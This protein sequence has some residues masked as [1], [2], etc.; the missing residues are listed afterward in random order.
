[1][2]WLSDST[3]CFKTFRHFISLDPS[4]EIHVAITFV[5]YDRHNSSLISEVRIKLADDTDIPIYFQDKISL[6]NLEKP[7]EERDTYMESFAEVLFNS[8]K[9]IL[10]CEKKL[11]F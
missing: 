2:K 9:C 3:E 10:L 6:F 7:N 5:Y 4:N 8:Y 1:M 11:P